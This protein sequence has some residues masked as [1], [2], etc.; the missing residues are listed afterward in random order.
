MGPSAN[1]R[2]SGI[3]TLPA[4]ERVSDR[5]LAYRKPCRF[6]ALYQP[7]TSA[8]VRRREDDSRHHG[9]LRLRKQC[10]RFNFGQQARGIGLAVCSSQT[11]SQKFL[12]AP[13]RCCRS[14]SA[15][16]RST[17]RTCRW[18]GLIAGSGVWCRCPKQPASTGLRPGKGKRPLPRHPI[19]SK[20][21]RRKC[22][23][24]PRSKMSGMSRPYTSRSR[25]T[26]GSPPAPS[27]TPPQAKTALGWGTRA[28]GCITMSAWTH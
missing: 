13:L 24:C 8:H 28:A 22:Q 20:L 12:L 16:T 4:R 26:Q 15:G 6:A 23:G 1:G 5:V 18:E 25:L 14:M 10:Q 27:N 3:E 9:R 21:R 2:C 7:C 17:S 11:L 19:R